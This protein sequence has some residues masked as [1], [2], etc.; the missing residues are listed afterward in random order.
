MK[1]RTL[2]WLLA[3]LWLVTSGCSFGG[4][5]PEPTG[6]PATTLQ[7]VPPPALAWQLGKEF[8]MTAIMKANRADEK[9]VQRAFQTCQRMAKQLGLTQLPPAP[10]PSSDKNSENF[11]AALGY[12]MSNAQIVSKQLKEI[13][14]EREVAMFDLAWKTSTAGLMYIPGDNLAVGYAEQLEKLGTQH[15]LPAELW[16]PVVQSIRAK[17]DSATVRGHMARMSAKMAIKLAEMELEK[18]E[19]T[20]GR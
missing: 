8:S 1:T 7:N 15:N 20:S 19:K 17:E 3:L 10:S 16:G 9:N 4:V 12:I 6:T 2:F 13:H 18:E 14:S 11:S 5:A